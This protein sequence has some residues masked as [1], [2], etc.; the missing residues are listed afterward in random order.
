MATPIPPLPPKVLP[1]QLISADLMNALIDEFARLRAG[2]TT[3]G[4]TVV[5]NNLFGLTIAQVRALFQQPAIQLA[6]G[7]VLDVNGSGVDILANEN[8]GLIVLVQDP[9]ANS[10]VNPG[11]PINIVV[12][13]S[14]TGGGTTTPLPNPTITRFESIAGVPGTAFRVGDSF[15]IV[16]T[17]FATTAGQNAVNIGGM[18]ANVVSD[19]G[20][21]TQRLTVTVPVG[22]PGA[23]TTTGG[24]PLPNVPIIVT[25][26]GSPPVTGTITVNGPA[27]TPPPQIITFTQIAV[28]G[29]SMNITGSNFGA[30]VALNRVFLSGT[31]APG[32]PPLPAG[33]PPGTIPAAIT[34]A[35]ATQ[36]VITVPNFGDLGTANGSSK[37]TQITVQVVD[38][39]SSVTGTVVSS[40]NATIFR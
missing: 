4:G 24:A 2:A 39:T 5:V 32:A 16:G 20:N 19:P 1:G 7:A 34:S 31:P 11:T 23:P 14:S 40:G 30:T 8:A 6:L 26:A 10:L 28:V 15:V 35:S 22:I 12:S 18:S 17:N 3:G 13:R 36:I 29:G 21:P 33:T 9:S 25:R 37:L 27:A 38:A